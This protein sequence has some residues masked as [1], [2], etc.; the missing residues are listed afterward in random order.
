MLSLGPAAASV[1]LLSLLLAV[2]GC[3]ICSEVLV[4]LPL[5]S[6]RFPG[7]AA[8]AADDDVEDPPCTASAARCRRRARAARAAGVFL[9]MAVV[10]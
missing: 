7:V 8:A 2:R 10:C 6:S 3:R 4:L 1:V 9:F 5:L